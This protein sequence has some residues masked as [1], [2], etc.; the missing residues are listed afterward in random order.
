MGRAE[1]R[2]WKRAVMHM[3]VYIDRE[4][5]KQIERLIYLEIRIS[6]EAGEQTSCLETIDSSKIMC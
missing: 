6:F 4:I 5:D 2:E 3:C 1:S